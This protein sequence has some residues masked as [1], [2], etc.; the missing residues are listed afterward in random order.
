MAFRRCRW[1]KSV[2]VSCGSNP[3]GAAYDAVTGSPASRTTGAGFER[4]F[5]IERR[6]FAGRYEGEVCGEKLPDCTFE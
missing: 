6:I 1:A 2:L 5:V 3:R 4:H